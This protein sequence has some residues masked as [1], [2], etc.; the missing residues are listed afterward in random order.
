[1]TFGCIKI[2]VI[3]TKI[4]KALNFRAFVVYVLEG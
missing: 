3:S 1:M 4:T 2:P